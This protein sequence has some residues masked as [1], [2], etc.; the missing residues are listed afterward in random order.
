M[1]LI[2][3][4]ALQKKVVHRGFDLRGIAES[5]NFGESTGDVELKVCRLISTHNQSDAL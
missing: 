5:F 2:L 1:K 3:L 4:N